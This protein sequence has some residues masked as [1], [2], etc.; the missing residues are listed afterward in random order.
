MPTT[1]PRFPMLAGIDF[2][3]RPTRRKP[4]A[5]ALGHASHGVVRLER[6]ELH[7][8]FESFGRWLRTPGP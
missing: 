7:A 1:S 6:I 2:T 5:V 3:S 8:E 4:I